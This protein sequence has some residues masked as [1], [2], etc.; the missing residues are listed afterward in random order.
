M[1]AEPY[2]E[3]QRLFNGTVEVSAHK[4][5]NVALQIPALIDTGQN[6]KEGILISRDF[7]TK[8]GLILEVVPN[9]GILLSCANPRRLPDP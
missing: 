9:S 3:T 2:R 4:G 8:L 5:K 7:C 1:I 6:I